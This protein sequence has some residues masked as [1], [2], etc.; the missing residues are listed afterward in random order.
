MASIFQKSDP[1]DQSIRRWM[2]KVKIGDQWKAV[3][4]RLKAVPGTKREAQQRVDS[5]Q[6]E[7]KAGVLSSSTRSWLGAIS[8]AKLMKD[9]GRG[10]EGASSD[11]PQSWASVRDGWLKANE[12]KDHR[13]TPEGR[14]KS[15]NTTGK[16]RKYKTKAFVDWLL[17]NE[18]PFLKDPFSA[19][20][21]RYIEH[22]KSAGV[23]AST[24]WNGDFATICALGEWMASKGIC[25][26]INRDSIREVMPVRPTVEINLPPWEEDLEMIRFYHSCRQPGEWSKGME[27]GK[28]S[29]MRLASQMSAWPVVLLIRGLGCR[30]SE[31][32]ALSWETVDLPNNRV[33]FIHSKNSKS[34]AVPIVLEWVRVGLGE[35]HEKRGRPSTGAVCLNYKGQFWKYDMG[36]SDLVN[37]ISA[38]NGRRNIKLKDMEKLQI[39][40]L[41]RLGFPPHVVAHWSDHSL[42]V[43][44]RHYYSGDSY[45]PPED[46]YDYG[47]FGE[48]S[49]YGKKV[50][51]H[52][53]GYARGAPPD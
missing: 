16:S 30:P 26:P 47:Q 2:G 38:R 35:L 15:S 52:Q 53:G 42:T 25:G 22:R 33:R 7:I 46:G 41:I 9:I 10:A 34:R 28:G 11:N 39:A 3:S 13:S 4:L 45:L 14:V 5:L 32:T 18:I 44:E 51:L 23:K 8:A 29:W 37:Q 31:A 17:A 1:K 12:A 49:E 20:A 50:L 27:A 43:Q 19:T 6:V 24:L 21:K 40:Q 48:L 36:V